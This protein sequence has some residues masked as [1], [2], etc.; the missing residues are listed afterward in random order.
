MAKFIL[1]DPS[2]SRVESKTGFNWVVF[3][4]PALSLWVA[5]DPQFGRFAST[6]DRFFGSHG[7]SN[8]YRSIRQMVLLPEPIRPPITSRSCFGGLVS[9]TKQRAAYISQRTFRISKIIKHIKGIS[10]HDIKYQKGNMKWPS[11]GAYDTVDGTSQNTCSR[12]LANATATNSD[13]TSNLPSRQRK[14]I[15]AEAAQSL[16][17]APFKACLLV[18]KLIQWS[19]WIGLE[20][21]ME[22]FWRK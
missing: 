19:K 10:W 14:Q 9:S 2:S 5:K 13:E 7:P 20:T 6:M 11:S 18:I 12:R 16:A 4:C 3:V 17:R 15:G 8:K 21:R 1:V 22:T